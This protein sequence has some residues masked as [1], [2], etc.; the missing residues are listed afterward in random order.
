MMKLS[1]LKNIRFWFLFLFFGQLVFIHAQPNSYTSQ[2]EKAIKL[3]QDA[4]N[5]FDGHQNEKALELLDKAVK[6]D[7]KFVEAYMLEAQ[8]YSELKQYEKAVE[9]YKKTFEIN[10]DFFPNNFFTCG[11]VEL[12]L[13][14]YADAKPLFEKFITYPRINPEFKEAADL[15][16]KSCDF[17]ME[18]IKHPVPFQPSNM[19]PSINTAESEYYPGI[20]ADDQYFLFTRSS[21]G[22]AQGVLQEDFFYSRKLNGAW[23][24]ALNL[25]PPINTPMNEGAPSISADGQ[26]LIFTGCN[27]PGGYG[28]CDLYFSKRVSADKWSRPQNMGPK[29]NSK[30]WESQPSISS[31]GKTLFFVSNRPGGFGRDNADIWMSTFENGDWTSPINLGPNINT[32][33]SEEAP[34]IHPD[35]K[36]LYFAST[37]RVGM[38]QSD[39]YVSRK[40]EDGT[41][42]EA[43]N[44]GYPINTCG[45][46][47]SLLVSASG[48]LAYF[49]SDKEGGFGGLDLYSFPLYE[50]ARP[51]KIS[52]MKGRVY[53]ARTKKPL[54]AN[55]ELIELSKGK[56]EIQSESNSGTGEFLI[57]LPS[58]K[59]YGLNVSKPGYLFYSENFSLA[60]QRDYKKP[61][62]KDVPLQPI[63]TGLKV[64]LKNVFFETAK[65][66][67]LDDSRAELDKLVDFLKFN[68]TIVIEISG[69]TD[70]FGD[71]KANILLSQNRAKAVNDYLIAHGIVQQRL[72][73]KGYGDTQPIA[74]NDTPEGR[75][76]NRR[77]EFKVLSK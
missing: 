45:N 65:F 6:K 63:D 31:D 50:G 74:S 52:Y 20:T 59:S 9:C 16:I 19:G 2:N 42:S 64:Q 13:G 3:M 68:N 69:H 55:F 40:N 47:I 30:F 61:F 37:G 57:C 17:A 44:L 18:A 7:P 15:Y 60:D 12:M 77:T 58:S 36:T 10:P 53:D 48:E 29:V 8:I 22:D 4:Y 49:G 56:T 72:K 35:T 41:W 54:S 14:K 70:N 23:Q 67:L 24:P 11:C 62:I 27:R 26:M 76:Q 71:K 28:A 66:N 46:E 43:K 25:G 34:F 21:R 33:G 73:F 32:T 39:I 38:G 5:L 75:Q 1:F 51:Q